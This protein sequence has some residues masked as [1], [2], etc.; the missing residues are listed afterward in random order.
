MG[1]RLSEI[2]ELGA[3]ESL[4]KKE[5]SRRKLEL[6]RP[7]AKQRIFHASGLRYRER[8]LRAGNQLGKSYCGSAECAYHLTGLYP[9]WWEGRRFEEAPRCWVGGV[10]GALVRD[11][12]QRLLLGIDGDGL[13]PS[14]SIVDK[15]LARGVSDLYDT[16]QVRHVSG[17]LSVCT[18]KYYE[19]GRAAWQAATLDFIFM[20]EEPPM[21]LYMEALSRTNA[22]GGMVYLTFTPLLGMSDVVARFLLEEHV[23][24]VEVNFTIEDAEHIDL[25]QRRR[26][27]EGYPEHERE[28]R[29]KGVPIL[30][31]GRIFPVAEADVFVERFEVPVHWPRVAGIDFGWDHPTAAVELAWDRDND[32]V[33][34]VREYRQK[35]G[36]PLQHVQVLRN[37]GDVPWAWPHDGLQHDKGSGVQLKEQYAGVGLRM[38]G[39]RA[40]YPNGSNSVEAGVMEILDRMKTGR[41]RVFSDCVNFLEEF[42]LYH[43]KDGKIVKERDDIISAARYGLMMLRHARI[44]GKDGKLP[45]LGLSGRVDDWDVF[46]VFS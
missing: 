10:T 20:D 3:L 37:W 16:V 8:L 21:D 28:A 5:L 1:L 13:I 15:T 35:E 40:T 43:R 33:Y 46:S 42:R 29:T 17:G 2:G 27:I 36:T 12:V 7:Y 26:I 23:D 11:G 31:S 25:E 30:G 6:Y 4:V 44:L 19:Q 24:R 38:M 18:F 45:K 9:D 14:K 39:E 32:R 34:V 22:T 41:F